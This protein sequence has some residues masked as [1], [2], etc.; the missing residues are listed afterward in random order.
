VTVTALDIVEF[1]AKA[2]TITLRVGDVLFREGDDGDAL[3]IVRRG[4]LQIVSGSTVYE[5]VT[6]GGIVGEMAIIEEGAPRSATVIATAFAEL[7]KIDTSNFLTLLA[8]TP[9][10]ALTV[11]REM[12]RRLRIMNRRYR[13]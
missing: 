11:M 7:I 6:A 3:Y 1:A 2:E 4:T 5:T 10:F 13:A 8:E 9:E 12:S